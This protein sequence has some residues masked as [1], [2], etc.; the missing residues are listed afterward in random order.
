MKTTKKW[1]WQKSK[2]PKYRLLR[3]GG[4]KY[5]VE[6]YSNTLECYICECVVNDED[7]A[8]QAVN[9]LE[10]PVKYFMEEGVNNA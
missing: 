9:N 7:E 6:K 8:E 3:L 5:S 1:F 4:G 2:K 10:E